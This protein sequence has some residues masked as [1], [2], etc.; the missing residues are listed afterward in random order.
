MVCAFDL[1]MLLMLWALRFSVASCC[2]RLAWLVCARFSVVLAV[3]V[4]VVLVV[5]VVVAGFVVVTSV[6]VRAWLR[7][8]ALVSFRLCR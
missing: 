8:F 6:L 2:R 7:Q 4:L 5:G 3:L 1:K